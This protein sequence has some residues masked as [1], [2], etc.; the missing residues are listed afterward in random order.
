[1]NYKLKGVYALVVVYLLSGCT[2]QIAKN[3]PKYPP[4]ENGVY[5]YNVIGW[6]TLHLAT[7]GHCVSMH[8]SK[9]IYI[10]QNSITEDSL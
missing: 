9:Q 2:Q 6:Q 7:P 1:M 8:L 10:L 3:S 5:C 4:Y